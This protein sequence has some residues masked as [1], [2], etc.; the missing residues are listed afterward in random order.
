LDFALSSQ[1]KILTME[2]LWQDIVQWLHTAGLHVG[3]S[4]AAQVGAVVSD[5]A[6]AVASKLDMGSL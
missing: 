6:T 5:G 1:R 2:T 3:K 4:A